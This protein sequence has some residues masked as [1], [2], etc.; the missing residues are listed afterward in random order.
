M[1]SFDRIR[2]VSMLRFI[3]L[4]LNVKILVIENE[5]YQISLFR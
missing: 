1:V 3:H 2:M 5:Q 4:R